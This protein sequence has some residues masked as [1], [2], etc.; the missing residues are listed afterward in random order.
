MLHEVVASPQ[1]AT[2]TPETIER[3]LR[4]I[5]DTRSA[6]HPVARMSGPAEYAFSP[7]V[8]LNL[9]SICATLRATLPVRAIADDIDNV[10]EPTTA[11][12]KQHHA[13]VRARGLPKAF[14]QH[15]DPITIGAILQE[16]RIDV[17]AHQ[18][19]VAQGWFSGSPRRPHWNPTN[20]ATPASGAARG[21]LVARTPE[22]VPN[23]YRR[24]PWSPESD[25]G[26]TG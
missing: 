16:L 22:Q 12:G 6:Q 25:C 8:Q 17:Q 4:C 9:N 23:G 19:S 14:D 26:A 2:Y 5:F 10:G 13:W 7:R 15:G 11:L 20:D 3:V 1:P 21:R 18:A 24:R